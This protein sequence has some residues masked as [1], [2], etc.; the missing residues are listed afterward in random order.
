M[1]CQQYLIT[2][3]WLSRVQNIK[4]LLNLQQIPGYVSQESVAKQI[5]SKLNGVFDRFWLDQIN[6][7]IIGSDNNDHNKLRF[8]KTLK[9]CFKTE[10]YIDLVHNRNQRSN[11]TRLRTSAHCLEVELLRY[12]V[13]AVPYYQRYCRYCTQQVPGDEEHFLMFCDSFLNK[14]QCF[15]GKLKALNPSFSSMSPNDLVKSMLCPTTTQSAK[16]VNKYILI[17]FRARNNIDEGLH[18][19]NLTF[20]PHVEHYNCPDV[21]LDESFISS[22]NC[23]TLSSDSFWESDID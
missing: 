22:S 3:S 4:Q 23:S 2:D 9:C 15:L 16:L 12:R 14:R 10:P 19:S 6:Q 7:T 18:I 20:P 21:S 11:L 5:K 13:P 8:Y 1:K 17:M